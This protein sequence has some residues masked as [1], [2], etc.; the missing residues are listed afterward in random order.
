M[1]KENHI[2]L[3]VIVVNYNHKYFPRMCVE[4]LE[5]SNTNFKFEIIVVDNNSHDESVDFLKQAHQE[6]R[7]T[8]VQSRVNLGYGKGN[9]LGAEYARGKYIMICNPDVFVQED[10]LQKM[11]SYLEEQ[12][13]VGLLGPKL[14]YYNGQIQDSCRR[15]RSFLDLVIKRTPLKLLPVF[16]KR[17]EKY[18]M[19]DFDHNSVQEVELLTGACFV[20]PT[21]LYRELKG[22]DERFFLF[23][24]DFDLCLRIHDKGYRVVYFPEAIC[25][26]YHKRLSQGSFL[27]QLAKKTFW[28]HV[29][30]AIKYFWKWRGRRAA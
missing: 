2:M 16:K 18:L 26:H 9:N 22:F 30:S 4:A 5:K 28:I 7:I 10:S 21:N 17:L 15:H 23:M 25:T 14:M 24:E 27:S 12:P 20:L 19:Q 29:S 13:K 8:L 6:G 3:S 1:N 11:L